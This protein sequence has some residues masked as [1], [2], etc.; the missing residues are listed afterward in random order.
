M[1]LQYLVSDNATQASVGVSCDGGCSCEASELDARSR[2]RESVFRISSFPIHREATSPECLISLLVLRR[3][4]REA[5]YFK[6]ARLGVEAGAGLSAHNATL[7]A[8][9]SQSVSLT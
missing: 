4:G 5:L 3:R 1:W 2:L 9:A 7:G 8:N 6:L